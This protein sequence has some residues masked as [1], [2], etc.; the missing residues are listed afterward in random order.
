[1]AQAQSSS[2]QVTPA[3]QQSAY[4][5]YSPPQATS[6]ASQR[7]A[8]PQQTVSPAVGAAQA[9]AAQGGGFQDLFRQF[10]FTPPAGF[11]D[12]LIGRLQGN[13]PPTTGHQGGASRPGQANPAQDPYETSTPYGG[14]QAPEISAVDR[15][16]Q[17]LYEQYAAGINAAG[18]HPG[19]AA[20]RYDSAMQRARNQAESEFR[21][22]RR[23]GAQRS[24][25]ELAA[26]RDM[27]DT[28]EYVQSLSEEE[29]RRMSEDPEAMQ[30]LE[31]LTTWRRTG[32]LPATRQQTTPPPIDPSANRPQGTAANTP[33]AT[34]Q[35]ATTS[36]ASQGFM[37][38][39]PSGYEQ[40]GS[41]AAQQQMY[42]N[43]MM[44]WTMPKQQ[45]LSWG[46]QA[47][48]MPWGP[49][50]GNM[51]AGQR[52]MPYEVQYDNP[53]GQGPQQISQNRDAFIQAILNQQANQFVGTY[54][55][56]GNPGPG[57]G[58]QP[59]DPS[60][61]MSQAQQILAGGW[62]NPFGNG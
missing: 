8:T 58:R 41:P 53:F 26:E 12:A 16:T 1:M 47:S 48:A 29:Q 33:Q 25:Q 13:A 43:S 60:Q 51:S 19:V 32:Q 50:Y 18:L 59:Y 37:P 10:N 4:A 42:N 17:E 44:A 39:P 38:P 7:Q 61:L 27:A 23:G 14:E 55:G 36:S 3:R 62:Q 22:P 11:I 34:G 24:P 20:L 35:Y 45:L 5:A 15:R 31:E 46:Q 52:P 40:F 30:M 6:A 49:N 2:R 54:A 28:W 21:Q 56:P 9:Q 57:Y